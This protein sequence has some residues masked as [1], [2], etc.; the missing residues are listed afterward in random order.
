VSAPP[1]RK[2]PADSARGIALGRIRCW[3]VLCTSLI[4]A[5]AALALMGTL[6]AELWVVEARPAAV[7][8]VCG[9]G[10]PACDYADIQ[11][12]VDAAAA[13]DVIKVAAGVYTGVHSRP[14]PAG[15]PNPPLGGLITQVAFIS[16][17]V[18]VRGG[19]TVTNWVTPDPISNSTTLDAMNQGRVLVISGLTTPI[20]Q[21]LR[22][23]GGNAAG[24]G[25]YAPP[26]EYDDAGGAIYV[27]KAGALLQDNQ[28]CGN[29]APFGGGVYLAGA[30]ATLERNTVCAN[31]AHDGAGIYLYDSGATLSYNT[32]IS[33]VAHD[34]GGV[35][36][37]D[38]PAVLIGNTISANVGD[39]DVGGL[40]VY[41]SAA[42]LIGN[43]LMVNAAQDDGGGIGIK[44]SDGVLVN[45][46]L[47][48]SNTTGGEGGGLFIDGCQASLVNNLVVGNRADRLGGGLYV[49]GDSL[50]HLLHTTIAS[51]RGGSAAGL[52]L[53]GG[54]TASLTN[55]VLVSHAVG[56]GVAAGSTATLEA[57]LWG[58][59]AWS[60]GAD[61]L[62]GGAVSTGTVNVWGDP[63][64]ADPAGGDFHIGLG[65]A[66]IDAGV[67]VLVYTDI[68]GQPR[69]IGMRP[70]LGADEFPM[71]LWVAKSAVPNPVRPGEQLTYT[72]DVSNNGLFTLTAS[73]TDTLPDQVTPTGTLSWSLAPMPPGTGLEALVVFTVEHGFSGWV[74]NVVQIRAEAGVSGESVNRVAVLGQVTYLPI[75]LVGR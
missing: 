3:V 44:W 74:T 73:V 70:D 5:A 29:T 63:T 67:K 43:T 54:S 53:T 31:T 14:A 33:N 65:S 52:Y 7:L 71:G 12:A 30:S 40:A 61:W 28:L 21:G 13:G 27:A 41:Q 1:N 42:T 75:I 60:N 10:W 69:P 16:K 11:G 47:V 58:D 8:T 9:T 68:D 18:T 37:Y 50:L 36:L 34:G 35:F 45:G 6:R 15:Y 64:F 32:V 2:R 46:N 49:A 26:D 20:V 38:S 55:T 23:T 25:G 57:T 39:D 17:T 24:L 51:N 59:G 4:G 62:G 48:L 72:I 56:I 19:Y 66:A 22:L